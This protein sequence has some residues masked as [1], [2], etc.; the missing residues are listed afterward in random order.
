MVEDS[1]KSEIERS[2]R[3]Q[4]SRSLKGERDQFLQTAVATASGNL[5]GRMHA[6]NGY[7]FEYFWHDYV[8]MIM[9]N[10]LQDDGS[11]ATRPFV[12]LFI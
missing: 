3:Y 4:L 7:L 12:L 1:D 6:K 8:K 5:N 10:N 11:D 2:G 9:A